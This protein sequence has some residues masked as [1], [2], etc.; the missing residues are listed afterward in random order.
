MAKRP[1]DPAVYDFGMT[2]FK[3]LMTSDRDVGVTSAD[4]EMGG[5]WLTFST[6]F[7]VPDAVIPAA[8]TQIQNASYTPPPQTIAPYF[9]YQNGDPAPLL[10]I[11]P[12]S[13]DDVTI[14]VPDLTKATPGMFIEAVAP[15]KGSIDADGINSFLVT[16]NQDAAGAIASGLTAGGAPPFTVECDLHEQFWIDACTVTVTADAD[17]VYDSMSAA[18]SE[19]G[20]LGICSAS[21]QAAYRDMQTSGVIQTTIQMDSGALTAAQQTWIQQY[22]NNVQTEFWNTAKSVIFDWDPTKSDPTGTATASQ[23]A[24]SSLF[25]GASVSMKAD[26]Q[27][28]RPDPAGFPDPGG[29]H[30]GHPGSLGRPQRRDAGGESQPPDLSRSRGHRAVLR[31]GAGRGHERGPVLRGSGRWH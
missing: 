27:Q 17:K 1:D 10:G 31:E 7:A 18:L 11:I 14:N 21:L 15:K 8:I 9:N 3:G 29:G 22:V 19:D 20:F 24:F 6:T 2:V 28:G 23:G 12:I 25:G 30:V 4:Q 13:E 26:Y 5:G 16:C